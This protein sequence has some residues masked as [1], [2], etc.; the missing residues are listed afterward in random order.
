MESV[1]KIKEALS[2]KS[3]T[4]TLDELASE[5]RKRV[6]LIRAEH[7]AQMVK[8]AVHAAIEQSGLLDQEQVDELVAQSRSEFKGLLEERQREQAAQR[9]LEER[10]ADQET[11]LAAN[12]EQLQ[13]LRDQCAELTETLAR[14]QADLTE[15]TAALEAAEAAAPAMEDAAAA[16]ATPATGEQPAMTAELMMTM[17][18]ELATL[19]ANL[20]AGGAGA[21]S[22]QGAAGPQ[23]AAAQDFTAALDKL[24]GTLNDRLDSIGKKVG[25]SAAVG[26]EA[27]VD[28]GAMFKDDDTP[29][30]SNMENIQVKQ[31]AVGGI[32]ANLAKL[33]KLKGGG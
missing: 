20:A 3:R 13:G 19:K 10:C 5:G 15:L 17:M 9:D 23:P 21:P 31:Q 30:E 24:A 32:A 18:Q 6:R 28:F 29:V 8:E 12:Q 16:K 25:I 2:A 26:G 7:I 11:Q 4:A 22:Q 27:P 1:T 33:K 14:R